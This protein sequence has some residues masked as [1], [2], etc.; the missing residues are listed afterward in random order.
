MTNITG[1][2]AALVAGGDGCADRRAELA[3]AKRDEG[4]VTEG[5]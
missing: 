1:H 4:L 2:E 5:P 3:G